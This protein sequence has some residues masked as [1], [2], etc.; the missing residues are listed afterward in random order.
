VKLLAATRSSGK[1]REFR[2]ILEPAG[3]ELAFPDDVGVFEEPAED[4]LE[5]EET[6]EANARHKA[7]YFARRTGLATVADDSGLEVFALGGEPGVRSRRWAGATGTGEQV[8]AAN[9]AYLLRRLAGAPETRRRARYRCVLVLFRT[10]GGIPEVFD[11]ACAGRI[12]EA[13]AG[14]GGF[15]Y[16]PLFWSDELDKSFGEATPEEKD[17]VS[18]RG[19]AL[20]ALAAALAPPAT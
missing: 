3:I 6:F 2:R 16:D 20:H 7:E 19:R 11:G 18:H 8:D 4:R 10:P 5:M 12:L 17:A 1:Q 9:N 13:P 15:G 14:T